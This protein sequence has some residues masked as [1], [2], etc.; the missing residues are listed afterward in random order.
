MSHGVQLHLLAL[1]GQQ[2]NIAGEILP[3]D[4][5][6]RKSTATNNLYNDRDMCLL[7]NYFYACS[8][9][10]KNDCTNKEGSTLTS[11][12]QSTE[13]A[14]T[15]P[16]H[17]PV[18]GLYLTKGGAKYQAGKLNEQVLLL[19]VLLGDGIWKVEQYK[20]KHVPGKSG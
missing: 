8:P 2:C 7:L 9:P 15:P 16:G 12:H 17:C 3:R 11:Q 1:L 10:T 4:Y 6:H 20:A 18:R 19:F 13:C 5:F 14:T